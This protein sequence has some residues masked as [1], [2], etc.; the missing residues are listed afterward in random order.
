MKFQAIKQLL[1]LLFLQNILIHS[2]RP[3]VILL[4]NQI[5]S[6]SLFA[7][8]SFPMPFVLSYLPHKYST[9]AQVQL[10][11]QPPNDTIW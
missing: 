11:L 7:V 4:K 8:T 5:I 2:F 9:E 6:H 1:I 10:P 3:S